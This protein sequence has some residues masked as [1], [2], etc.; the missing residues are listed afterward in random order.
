MV[1]A[2]D[3]LESCKNQ[4]FMFSLLESSIGIRGVSQRLPDPTIPGM[5]LLFGEVSL[6][7]QEICLLIKMIGG[8]VGPGL[9][10]YVS[11]II[12]AMDD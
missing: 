3:V 4:P 7:K 6:G 12:M 8:A 10:R 2:F 1:E 11:P 5:S 9:N